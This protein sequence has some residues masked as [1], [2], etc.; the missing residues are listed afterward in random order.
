[1]EALT[2]PWKPYRSIGKL[3]LTY[4]SLGEG[5]FQVQALTVFTGVYYMWRLAEEKAS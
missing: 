4:V 3:T 1:M 2:E 5:R